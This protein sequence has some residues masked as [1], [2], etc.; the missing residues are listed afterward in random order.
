MLKARN[1][2]VPSSAELRDPGVGGNLEYVDLRFVTWKT[3]ESCL[4]LEPRLVAAIRKGGNEQRTRRRF[5][6]ESFLKKS[7]EAEPTSETL[8]EYIFEAQ[9][10]F[11]DKARLFHLIDPG[12]ISTVAALAAADCPP[13]SSCNGGRF[14]CRH[15]ERAPVVAFFARPRRLRL[16]NAAARKA[17]VTIESGTYGIPIISGEQPEDL[18]RFA[19]AL[20]NLRKTSVHRSGPSKR[21]LLR[22]KPS[23]ADAL[24]LTLL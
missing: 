7:G 9:G 16:L 22:S 6:Y 8:D 15:Q 23:V 24:Q 21:R 18:L 1:C 12:C 11:S 5:L 2:F 14:G 4:S 17:G 13:I 3:A 10:S 19:Y 20:T